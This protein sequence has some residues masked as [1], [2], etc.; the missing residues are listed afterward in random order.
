MV[1]HDIGNIEVI[2]SIPI[3]GSHMNR[4]KILLFLFF[5][6]FTCSAIF[7]FI[8]IKKEKGNPEFAFPGFGQS[9]LISL[10]EENKLYIDRNGKY[11][12]NYPHNNDLGDWILELDGEKPSFY[13]PSEKQYLENKKNNNK[14]LEESSTTV[15]NMLISVD[16]NLAIFSNG[17]PKVQNLK[18]YTDTYLNKLQKIAD[19]NIEEPKDI[20]VDNISAKEIEY[21]SKKTHSVFTDVLIIKD[22]NVYKISLISIN[23]KFSQSDKDEFQESINSFKFINL[24]KQQATYKIM[25]NISDETKKTGYGEYKGSELKFKIKYPLEWLILEEPR[26]KM[27]EFYPQVSYY[28]KASPKFVVQELDSSFFSKYS[29]PKEDID[30]VEKYM[31]SRLNKNSSFVVSKI[32]LNGSPAYIFT[33]NTIQRVNDSDVPI[34]AIYIL[35]SKYNRIYMINYSSYENYF[36]IFFDDANEMINSFNIIK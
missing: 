11:Q 29:L 8:Y 6:V 9:K 31:I 22:D 35:V 33:I 25:S 18:E 26:D 7:V 16:D 23:N 1:E 12:I 34:K 32:T 4:K 10:R 17:K 21:N 2:G 30:A 13:P 15:V 27:M 19:Y 20:I 28:D 24:S 14:N 36:D 3:N 5:A